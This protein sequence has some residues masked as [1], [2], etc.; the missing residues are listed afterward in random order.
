MAFVSSPYSSPRMARACSGS[1]GHVGNFSV[2]RATSLVIC[3]ITFTSLLHG[4]GVVGRA[5]GEV[6]GDDLR[7]EQLDQCGGVAGRFRGCLLACLLWGSIHRANLPL[8]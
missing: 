4:L 5:C 3:L 2:A 7:G 6:L 1:V 8:M